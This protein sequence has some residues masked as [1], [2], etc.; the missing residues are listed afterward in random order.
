M[1]TASSYNAICEDKA[2]AFA[3][4]LPERAVNLQNDTQCNCYVGMLSTKQNK[5]YTYS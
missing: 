1:L 2:P 5:E 3:T 4:W